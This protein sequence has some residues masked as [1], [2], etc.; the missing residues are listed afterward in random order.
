MRV[1]YIFATT[2]HTVSYKLQQMIMPQL[3]DDRHGADIA[4]M[5]FFDDNTYFFQNGNTHAE[6]LVEIAKERDILL[7][8]C[9]QCAMERGFAF[10][11]SNNNL[12]GWHHYASDAAPHGETHLIGTVDD[13]FIE[14]GCFPDL[15]D[16]LSE[17]PP[18]N[19]ITL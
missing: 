9:D 18:D 8:L 5:F 2:G 19:I 7:M 15:Y 17:D 13:Q 16:A 4:G 14:V 6:M 10:I 1:A 3:E 12:E 11:D